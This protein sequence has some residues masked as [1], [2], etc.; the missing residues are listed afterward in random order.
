VNKTATFK[1]LDDQRFEYS[2]VCT[3]RTPDDYVGETGAANWSSS[4]SYKK[5]RFK[6]FITLTWD[7]DT[8]SAKDVQNFG[9]DDSIKYD[10]QNDVVSSLG[11]FMR[12]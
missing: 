10:G 11:V 6:P 4:G 9:K 3:V 5:E 1:F 8:L 7:P 2:Y 12:V